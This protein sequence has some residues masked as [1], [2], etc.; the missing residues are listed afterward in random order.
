MSVIRGGIICESLKPGTVIEGYKLHVTR[1][2]RYE[3]TGATHWQPNVWTL[4]EFEASEDDSDALAQRLSKD[5]KEPGWYA[6]WNSATEAT[7]VFPEKIF[8]YKRGDKA[9][10]KKVQRYGLNC[11]VPEP[12]LD[13]DD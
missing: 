12:Q 11:G 8:R 4:I 3:V 13:W 5:L 2:S 1:W 6:N 10:R 7:V 9:A